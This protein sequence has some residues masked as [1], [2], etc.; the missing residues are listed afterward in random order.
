[1]YAC[2]QNAGAS[3]APSK[4]PAPPPSKFDPSNPPA[5]LSFYQLKEFKR[6]DPHGDTTAVTAVPDWYLGLY[7][8]AGKHQ[9]A[10]TAVTQKSGWDIIGVPS[11][12]GK[13]QGQ[14]E[15][16]LQIAPGGGVAAAAGP[17]GGRK[18][19]V[20]IPPDSDSSDSGQDGEDDLEIVTTDP[21]GPAAFLDSLPL[22]LRRESQRDMAH[23]S[24]PPP[25]QRN[26]K[27]KPAQQGRGRGRRAG[28]GAGPLKR[29]VKPRLKPAGIGGVGGHAHAMYGGLT[30]SQVT[31]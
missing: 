22:A 6:S 19:P 4:L 30:M 14:A 5:W 12:S 11:P 1:M 25:K 26:V 9:P 18:G 27:P 13:A 7:A 31:C 24:L 20:E 21:P 28:A 17:A 29:P 8:T 2:T 16:S 10:V 15:M 3:I 23:P